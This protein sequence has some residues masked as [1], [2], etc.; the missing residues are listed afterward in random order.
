MKE[1]G[2]NLIRKFHLRE[3]NL[4]FMGYALS[5]KDQFT[6]HHLIIPNCKNGPYIEWNGAILC[7]A[8]SHPYLH[9]IGEVDYDMFL[10]ITKEMIIQNMKG[11]L[12]RKNLLRIR[13]ILQ[14]FEKEY[15]G[16]KEKCKYTIKEE[17]LK[18]PPLDEPLIRKRKLIC[19]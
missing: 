6:F 19:K 12:D 15:Y 16:N 2:L 18:R 9:I 14:S 8:S 7:G 13:S 10:A 11:H 3:I 5:E 4:D 17:Y 1:P